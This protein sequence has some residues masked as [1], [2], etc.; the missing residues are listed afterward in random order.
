MCVCENIQNVVCTQHTNRNS[1]QIKR[2]G[3][4]DDDIVVAV[5]VNVFPRSFRSDHRR[6]RR[7]FYIFIS[8]HFSPTVC[9]QSFPPC[10]SIS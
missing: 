3:K 4:N 9:A 2:V 5:V 10:R 6:C 1:R 7:F 8:S